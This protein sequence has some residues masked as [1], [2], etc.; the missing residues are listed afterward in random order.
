M[1]NNNEIGEKPVGSGRH[2]AMSKNKKIDLEEHSAALDCDSQV[3]A[4]KTI[5]D[6]LQS[7]AEVGQEYAEDSNDPIGYVDEV[8]DELR[9][10][11]PEIDELADAV[12]NAWCNYASANAATMDEALGYSRP[13]HWR[14]EA[15]KFRYKNKYMI[16]IEVDLLNEQGVSIEDAFAAVGKKYSKSSGSIKQLYY[17]LI[18]AKRKRMQRYH[19]RD[20]SY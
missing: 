14:Q 6:A 11:I 3:L 12:K 8:L 15:E 7:I 20:E 17:D 10:I 4:L 2:P 18:K 16:Q 1:S 5:V 19:P 13:K 9:E